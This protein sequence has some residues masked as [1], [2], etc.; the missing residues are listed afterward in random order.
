MG[1]GGARRVRRRAAPAAG[2]DHEGDQC[3]SRLEL[4]HA[5]P[6]SNPPRAVWRFSAAVA[7]RLV[8]A[9]RLDEAE[10]RR[11]DLM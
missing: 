6:D 4:G 1:R 7:M 10:V 2:E 8:L 9:S 11:L 3:Q 5:A